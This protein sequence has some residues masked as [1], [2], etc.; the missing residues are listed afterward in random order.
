MKSLKESLKNINEAAGWLNKAASASTNSGN[1]STNDLSD[2]AKKVIEKTQKEAGDN[3]DKISEQY[4]KVIS[5]IDKG[6]QNMKNTYTDM[7]KLLSASTEDIETKIG[8]FVMSV[9]ESNKNAS[10]T[11]QAW[12][13]DSSDKALQSMSAFSIFCIGILSASKATLKQQ[14]IIDA[15]TA[16]ASDGQ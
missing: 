16:M 2:T 7:S 11:I 9:L 8:D 3:W 6:I 15:I 12:L 14:D 4:T 1:D 10:K 5:L 13:D